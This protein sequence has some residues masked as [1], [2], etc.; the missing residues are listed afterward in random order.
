MEF[1]IWV[2]KG[3]DLK[4]SSGQLTWF[5]DGYSFIL[6]FPF[7]L[8]ILTPLGYHTPT[9]VTAQWMDFRVMHFLFI[10]KYVQF[11]NGPSVI[12]WFHV[13]NNALKFSC[14]SNHTKVS[15]ANSAVSHSSSQ[16]LSN[17]GWKWG[18]KF[19]KIYFP[20]IS[21]LVHLKFQWTRL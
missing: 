16:I 8:P 20:N 17:V 14:H 15:K 9:L 19:Q 11:H 5:Q 3:S 12:L 21:Y 6:T 2:G 13:H 7:W 10:S 4:Q 18:L 1:S